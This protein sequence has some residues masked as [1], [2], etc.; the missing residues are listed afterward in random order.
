MEIILKNGGECEYAKMV[1][2]L[3]RPGANWLSGLRCTGT[4]NNGCQANH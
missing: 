1:S 4:I 3:N 2:C